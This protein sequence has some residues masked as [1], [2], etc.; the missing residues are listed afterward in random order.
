MSVKILG[1]DWFEVVVQGA[2]T[3]VFGVAAVVAMSSVGEGA[4]REALE[5][6]GALGID[7]NIPNPLFATAVV[8]WFLGTVVA[9][10]MR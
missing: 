5:Q 3:I 7:A 10:S 1:L 9:M 6:I 4:R 2:I 8:L